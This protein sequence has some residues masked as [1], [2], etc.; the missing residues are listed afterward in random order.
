[1]KEKFK[2][3]VKDFGYLNEQN[4]TTGDFARLSQQLISTY[5]I[6]CRFQQIMLISNMDLNR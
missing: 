5:N 1:M 6:N 2:D 4:T 3:I